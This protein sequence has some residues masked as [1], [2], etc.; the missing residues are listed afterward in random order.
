[1]HVKEPKTDKDDEY[2]RKLND[3]LNNPPAPGSSRSAG[4]LPAELAGAQSSFNWQPYFVRV[5]C[6]YCEMM[7]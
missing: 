2:A 6:L 4:G 3:V 1:M 7:P 5:S